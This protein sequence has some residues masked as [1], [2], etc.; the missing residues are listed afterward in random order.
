MFCYKQNETCL[1]I[2]NNAALNFYVVWGTFLK[3]RF[4]VSYVSGN[5]FLKVYFLAHISDLKLPFLPHSTC[6]FPGLFYIYRV[7][8]STNLRITFINSYFKFSMRISEM[9]TFSV[10]YQS[11]DPM[12]YVQ[13]TFGCWAFTICQ[14]LC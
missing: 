5:Y 1:T 3:P 8:Q 14:I 4:H 13:S 9:H 6:Y 2:T 11:G 7:K 12:L 10:N